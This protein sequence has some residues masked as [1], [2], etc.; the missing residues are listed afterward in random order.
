[1]DWSDSWRSAFRIELRAEA[2]GLASRGWPVLPGTCPVTD[3]QSG[4]SP[5][6]G[7]PG[8]IPVHADWTE[9][10]GASADEV[11]SWWNGEPRSLLAAT[12][13]VLNAVEVSDQ[14]GRRTAAMLR[15]NGGPVPIV[16]TPAGRWLFLVQGGQALPELADSADITVHAA[17]SWV[18]LPPSPF[19]HGIAHWR[20][21]PEVCGWRL[22]RATVVKDAIVRAIQESEMLLDAQES[23]ALASAEAA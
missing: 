16:A 1:M 4:E 15:Q 22:P 12:G 3:D 2:I 9:R 13:T 21:K 23:F 6:S 8:P 10:I 19:Q 7:C 20:V 18:P 11:A 5:V 14:L 17:G